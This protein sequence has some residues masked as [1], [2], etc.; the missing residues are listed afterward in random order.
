MINR[1]RN[2]AMPCK[3]CVGG[4]CCSDN[5]RL[6]KSRTIDK[7]RKAVIKSKIL[8]AREMSVSNRRSCT[9]KATSR[10]VWGSRISKLMKGMREAGRSALIPVTPRST[11]PR[12]SCAKSGKKNNDT[13]K[14]ARRTHARARI[15]KHPVQQILQNH[16]EGCDATSFSYLQENLP[17]LTASPYR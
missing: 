13:K 11:P 12:A 8:G 9:E 3:T 7:R 6:I 17:Q 10:L 5:A 14:S 1:A 4:T 2:N 15:T 16:Y